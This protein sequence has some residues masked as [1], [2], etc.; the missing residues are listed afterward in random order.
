MDFEGFFIILNLIWG[1]K[2]V[3]IE[4]ILLEREDI[5]SV[6][7]LKDIENIGRGVEYSVF[8]TFFEI[9]DFLVYVVLNVVV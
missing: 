2:Y 7:K 4:I 6:I 3:L 8:I 1:K 9:L 5:I